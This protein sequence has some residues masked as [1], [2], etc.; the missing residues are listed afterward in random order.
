MISISPGM[1]L[2]GRVSLGTLQWTTS[3]GLNQ[4]K[5]QFTIVNPIVTAHLGGSIYVDARDLSVTLP[6]PDP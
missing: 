5:I 6:R 1:P 3:Q 2:S 4:T